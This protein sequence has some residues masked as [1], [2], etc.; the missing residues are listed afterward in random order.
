[1]RVCDKCGKEVSDNVTKTWLSENDYCDDC[2]EKLFTIQEPII[3]KYREEMIN[4]ESEFMAE[5][6]E[7]DHV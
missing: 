6:P 5:L 1:M 4:T 2:D 7:A 3:K